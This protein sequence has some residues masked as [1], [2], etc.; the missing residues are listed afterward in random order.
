MFVI[1]AVVHCWLPPAVADIIES[2]V[3]NRVEFGIHQEP[4]LQAI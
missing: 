4:D 2:R 3:E 1:S